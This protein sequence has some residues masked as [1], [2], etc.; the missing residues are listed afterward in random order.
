MNADNSLMNDVRAF[1]VS[2]P[3]LSKTLKSKVAVFTH[4]G[5]AAIGAFSNTAVVSA[6]QPNLD[7]LW[8]TGAT[9]SVVTQA[10]VDRLNL[11]P[12]TWGSVS[13]PNGTYD[14]PF[15]YIYI[16]LP[17]HVIVGPL[18]VP[19]GNPSECDILI[20]MDVIGSGDLAVSNHN[21][22]TTFTFRVPSIETTD[23]VKKV[24]ISNAVGPKHG[25]GKRKR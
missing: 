23:Y 8:D 17:N 19:L 22:R 15:F 5:V 7:G 20:G 21:G 2:Y 13:T 12:V 16:G 10:V 24:R 14:T 6:P 4:K 25:K 9:C 1:T 3:G 11:V 18:L